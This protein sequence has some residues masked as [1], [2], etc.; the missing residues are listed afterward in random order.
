MP[1]AYIRFTCYSEPCQRCLAF[2]DSV[3]YLSP[4]HKC[5]LGDDD[6]GCNLHGNPVS[7][8]CLWETECIPS[9]CGNAT[10][11]KNLTCE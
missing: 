6:I 8:T 9:V 2:W 1:L 7:T 5:I 11:L 10:V 4:S 3:A